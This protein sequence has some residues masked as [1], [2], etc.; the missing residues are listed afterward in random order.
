MM[1]THANTQVRDE[2]QHEF[3]DS[4]FGQH[5][6]E[7]RPEFKGQDSYQNVKWRDEFTKL[8]LPLTESAV[9]FDNR[10]HIV[11]RVS[12]GLCLSNVKKDIRQ[13][14]EEKKRPIISILKGTKNLIQSQKDALSCDDFPEIGWLFK[15]NKQE[16]KA[17]LKVSRPRECSKLYRAKSVKSFDSPKRQFL[18]VKK[19]PPRINW[20][21][22]SKT[23]NDGGSLLNRQSPDFMRRRSPDYIKSLLNPVLSKNPCKP[24]ANIRH[25]VSRSFDSE[26]KE[27]FIECPEHLVPRT[28]RLRKDVKFEETSI[29]M[30][31]S[32]TG[33]GRGRRP[34]YKTV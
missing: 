2:K 4:I 3:I 16:T 28:T 11:D 19:S 20:R 32:G 15:T 23:T 27:N 22:A 34:F 13:G 18:V 21:D 26:S 8:K 33:R 10:I 30:A 14:S 7:I 9:W 24:A 1:N 25:K 5:G 6:K 17:Y 29:P 12:F 31:A